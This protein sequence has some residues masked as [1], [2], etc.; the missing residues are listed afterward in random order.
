[1]PFLNNPRN[2][3]P[4][5]VS[6]A[7]TPGLRAVTVAGD[8]RG[9]DSFNEANEKQRWVALCASGSRFGEALK[10]EQQRLQQLRTEAMSAAGA[11][12]AAKSIADHNP[13][14]HGTSELHK[15]R[16]DKTGEF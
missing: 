4:Q 6:S 11:H 7:S 3:A 15:R 16:F 14:G 1:M 12:G 8:N 2:V 10:A 9:G 13:F 5:L